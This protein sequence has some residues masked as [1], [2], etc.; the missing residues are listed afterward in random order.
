MSDSAFRSSLL[1]LVLLY[2]L[3]SLRSLSPLF[4]LREMLSPSSWIYLVPALASLSSFCLVASNRIPLGPKVRSTRA[5]SVRA[6]LEPHSLV[7]VVS[8]AGMG[9]V[10]VR[11]YLGLVVGGAF[12]FMAFPC[13]DGA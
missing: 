12:N 5:D 6:M 9:A 1:Q 7:G 2:V 10:L 8:V 4:A 13:T 11:C 3:L